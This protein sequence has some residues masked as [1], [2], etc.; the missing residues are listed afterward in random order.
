MIRYHSFYPWHREGA[1]A[2]FMAPDGRDAR[3]LAA[4]REFNRYDLYSKSDEVPEVEELKVSGWKSGVA[5]SDLDEA[6]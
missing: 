6:D 1:Y 3:M 2:E 5:L 4:V